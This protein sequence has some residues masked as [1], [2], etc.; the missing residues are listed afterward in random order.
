MVL[1]VQ[2]IKSSRPGN[3]VASKNT[4]FSRLGKKITTET[5]RKIHILTTFVVCFEGKTMP[6]ELNAIKGFDL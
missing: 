1:G 2:W 5:F 4:E 6:I 3:I